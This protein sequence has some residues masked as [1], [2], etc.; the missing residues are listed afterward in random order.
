MT[1]IKIKT[2][3][4]NSWVM[5]VRVVPIVTTQVAVVMSSVMSSADPTYQSL[6]FTVPLWQHL[7]L[8]A[9]VW[10][11]IYC[12]FVLRYILVFGLL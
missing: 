7:F 2:L 9:P 12:D 5:V 1:K 11:Y 4:G 10:S 3:T 8:L 6:V